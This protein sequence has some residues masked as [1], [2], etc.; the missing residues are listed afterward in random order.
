[1]FAAGPLAVMAGRFTWIDWGVVFATLAFATWLG[2][3]KAGK[4]ATIREFFLGGRRLPWWAV[5]GSIIATEI[6]ALTFVSVPWRV[7]QPG[8]N[9]T[10]LQLGL[11]GSVLARVI[12]GYLLV[13]AYYQ[14]E[15]YSPYDYMGH[16]LGGP[17]RSMT[18]SLFVVG[19]LLGQA[20]RV[21]L[22]AMVLT[23][24]MHDELAMLALRF[25]GNPLGWAIGLMTVVAVVWTLMGGMTTV[26]WTE[27]LLFMAFVTGA[28]TALAT[29]VWHLDGG[30]AQL[31]R[32]GFAAKSS[33]VPWAP[34]G[35]PA[36]ECGPWGKFTL[37]DFSTDPTRQ[38]T[39]W[40]AMIA[41]T[42]GGVGAYGTDQLMAQRMFCCRNLADARKA[43]ILSATS[44]TVTILVA[45]LGIGLFVYYQHNVP[46]ADALSLLSN[47]AG[48]DRIFPVFVVEVVPVGLKG[49]ILSA[50]FAAA[51]SSMMGILTALSQTVMSAFYNPL[52]ERTLRRRGI[53]PVLVANL[54]HAHETAA[55]DA[56]A[57][58]SVRVGRL[59]VVLCGLALS[60]CAYCA[61]YAAAKQPAL[62]DLGQSLAGYAG[63]GLLAGFALAFLPL[64]IDGRGYLW[65]APLSFLTILS[66]AWH[67]DPKTAWYADWTCLACLVGGGVLTGTWLLSAGRDRIR[68]YRRGVLPF[69][70]QTLLLIAGCV[71]VV[72]LNLYGHWGAGPLDRFGNPTFKVLA[73]PWYV[74]IGSTVAFVWGYFLARRRA[75]ASE[76]EVG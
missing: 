17:V 56:E 54:E 23:V 30:V 48:G 41:A 5:C 61:Q 69:A 73:W 55:D 7:F 49:L 33:G 70:M 60:L 76:A 75:A 67:H 9:L 19:G 20:A 71:G 25:G 64:K 59:F 68:G 28:L 1:M 40:T 35:Q 52:R 32:E 31:I 10:Y 47:R 74:P 53:Q 22:T 63:G 4:Q 12:V 3:K 58:R 29:V 45:F 26:I 44:I 42:W 6:S 21:Y 38:F 34:W 43:I 24:V 51:I 8:G 62:L 37:F 14:R 11:I 16:Q 18:T 39:I 46:S 50:I 36:V 27:L 2:A 65:S 72:L 57:Q 13:P 66:I 15:I